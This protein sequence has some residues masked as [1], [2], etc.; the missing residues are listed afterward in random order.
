MLII[1]KQKRSRQDSKRLSNMLPGFLMTIRFTTPSPFQGLLPILNQL[2]AV[3]IRH[4]RTSVASQFVHQQQA[5]AKVQRWTPRIKDARGSLHPRINIATLPYD[6]AR[7][8]GASRLVM[9]SEQGNTMLPWSYAA[10]RGV[11]RVRPRRLERDG[12]NAPSRGRGLIC[13][14]TAFSLLHLGWTHY[15]GGAFASR[16]RADG[17]IRPSGEISI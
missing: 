10:S 4:Q 13:A 15:R 8:R 9:P 7:S 1:D 6:N 11:G 14:E 3:R 12:E 16:G 5:M 2:K 17:E